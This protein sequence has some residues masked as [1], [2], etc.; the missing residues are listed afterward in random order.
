VELDRRNGEGFGEREGGCSGVDELVEIAVTALQWRF[1]LVSYG[2]RD[3]EVFFLIREESRSI[4]WRPGRTSGP[5]AIGRRGGHGGGWLHLSA[6]VP[7][8]LSRC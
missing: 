5:L 2:G 3:D 7:I 1:F 8:Y 6:H 4:E